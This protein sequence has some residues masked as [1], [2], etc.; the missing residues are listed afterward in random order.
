[1]GRRQSKR[2]ISEIRQIVIQNDKKYVMFN[3][4]ME[5]ISRILITNKLNTYLRLSKVDIECKVY[6]DNNNNNIYIT[7]KE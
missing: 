5:Y 4:N 6:N 1:M 7:L 3:C 2:Y